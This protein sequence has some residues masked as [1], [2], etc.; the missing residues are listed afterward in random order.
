MNYES[1][2]QIGVCMLYCVQ[3]QCNER[4]VRVVLCE[5]CKHRVLMHVSVVRASAY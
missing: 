2:P 4:T 1:V 3:G 5:H